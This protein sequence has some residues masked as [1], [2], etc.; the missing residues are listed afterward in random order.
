MGTRRYCSKYR[1]SLVCLLIVALAA[2]TPVWAQGGPD[3]RI[4]M[5]LTTTSAHIGE[6]V[7]YTITITNSGSS[8]LTN[9]KL[10]APRLGIVDSAIYGGRVSRGAVGII[11]GTFTIQESD[12]P[13][14]LN[15]VAIVS[16]DQ[17]GS[18]TATV[19]ITIGAALPTPEI[20]PIYIGQTV[21]WQPVRACDRKC[22]SWQLYQTN[23]TGDWEIFRLDGLDTGVTSHTNLT[24]TIGSGLNDIA[25]S[26]S[27][28]GNWMTFASNRDGNWEIYLSRI[29]GSALQRITENA[30]ASDLNPVWGPN[31][32][33]VYQSNREGNWK[34]YLFDTVTGIE[35]KLTDTAADDINPIW[36]PNGVSIA[37]QSNRDSRWQIYD[38]HPETGILNRLSNGDRNDY[39]PV[40]SPDGTSIAFR[41]VLDG[42][43][44]SNIAIMGARGGSIIPVTNF[45]GHASH[46][47]WSADSRLLAYQSDVDGDD[48]IYLFDIQTRETRQLTDNN[49]SDYAPAFLCTGSTLL[50]NA[51][52]NGQADI[53]QLDALA[54]DQ[55]PKRLTA[56][57]GDSLYAQ[58]G[59]LPELST[60][61]MQSDLPVLAAARPPYP[62]IALEPG[63]IEPVYPRMTAWSPV[64]ACEAQCPA[65]SVYTGR[66]QEHWQILRQ[67]IDNSAPV[68]LSRLTDDN[69]VLTPDNL[70]PTLS[71]NGVWVV[72][73]S[74]RDKY[75]ELYMAS[76]DGTVLPRRMTFTKET[77]RNPVW[78]PDGQKI[79]YESNRDGN[80]E[81]YTFDISSGL[82]A[83]LTFNDADDIAGRWSSDASKIVFQSNRSNR[84]QIYLLDLQTDL[85]TKLSDGAG[86]DSQPVFSTD[87]QYVA[88]RS[89]R[90]D[91]P[92]AV[93]VVKN[94]RDGTTSFVSD[95]ARNAAFPAW[96][97]RGALLA[98]QSQTAD[99]WQIVIYDA[100]TAQRWSPTAP[101]VNAFAPLWGCD[102]VSLFVNVLAD[103]LTRIYVLDAGNAA[104]SSVT[105][106]DGLRSLNARPG[107]SL[108]A[109]YSAPDGSEWSL[110]P[111]T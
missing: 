4:E 3:I 108:Y 83:R 20:D 63:A 78:S 55:S 91:N 56:A 53:Y 79:L 95:S 36:S 96:S 21:R 99:G 59:V 57:D 77:E 98:Y 70:M 54:A 69:I 14:P 37:F 46:P 39:E 29:D 27:P 40:Y 23:Q 71:P 87:S 76:S 101:P 93:I 30:E 45:E 2:V 6:S 12:F 109:P 88:F 58:D 64:N 26:R 81:L 72:F 13:G 65:W 107:D 110:E 66:E 32:Y 19:T 17:T 51:E 106:V 50:F 75:W 8:D 111:E 7:G 43:Q 24:N 10:N 100:A 44:S 38:L 97:L 47:A 60:T 102:G 85:I 16:S 82:E 34:L 92:N 9:V 11:Q 74:N 61:A 86:E 52:N 94:L 103:G 49:R 68:N 25:P 90:P 1:L 73:A 41:T 18:P 104:A 84:Q 105:N 28:D 89:L 42:K 80:W 5:T 35:T 48:E 33:I 31:S 22:V 62:V 67:N 15:V